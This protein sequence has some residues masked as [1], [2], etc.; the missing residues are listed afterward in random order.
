MGASC[1]K[2]DAV[3]LE[4]VGLSGLLADI[5]FAFWAVTPWLV[6]LGVL[7]GLMWAFNRADE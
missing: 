1:W 3:G 2:I 5:L 6:S 7:A 4:A